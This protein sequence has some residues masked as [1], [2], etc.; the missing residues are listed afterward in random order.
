[1]ISMPSVTRVLGK[2]DALL[3]VYKVVHPFWCEI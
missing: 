2:T 1:M 3:V